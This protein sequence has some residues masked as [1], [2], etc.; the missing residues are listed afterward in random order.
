MK[1][2]VVIILLL[3]SC[4]GGSESSSPMPDPM[5]GIMWQ[6]VQKSDECAW[7]EVFNGIDNKNLSFLW[8]SYGS[9]R[10]CLDRFLRSGGSKLLRIYLSN[11]VCIRKKNCSEKEINSISDIKKA[12]EEVSKITGAVIQIVPQLE[13]NWTDA[14]ACEVAYQLRKVTHHEIWRNPVSQL[15]LSASFAC[16]DGIELHG[17]RP[18]FTSA[19]ASGSNDG[20]SL[21]LSP[22][23]WGGLSIS[24]DDANRERNAFGRDSYYFLWHAL[25]NCLKGDTANAPFPYQRDCENRPDIISDLNQILLTGL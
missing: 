21:L 4:G 5:L 6:S 12:A 13:D 14:Y 11:G 10:I 16:F 18:L 24:R 15:Q 20:R 7:L 23:E 8:G 3:V 17:E 19:N 25:G 2:L 1:R 9:N 22:Y